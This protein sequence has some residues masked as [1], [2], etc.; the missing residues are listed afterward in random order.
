MTEKN[1]ANKIVENACVAASQGVD[2]YIE[3]G[4]RLQDEMFRMA[5]QQMKSFKDYSEFALKNQ[6]EFFAQF[7]KNA[8]ST[9]DMW[10]EGLKKWK[11]TIEKTTTQKD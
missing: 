6:V 7:E 8:K 10:V 4:V 2:E 9:R 5:Q 11:A 1:T 3:M